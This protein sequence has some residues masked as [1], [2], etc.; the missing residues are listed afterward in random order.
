MTIQYKTI[1]SKNIFVIKQYVLILEG[2]PFL[3]FVVSILWDQAFEFSLHVRSVYV[4]SLMVEM[5]TFGEE[6]MVESLLSRSL[7]FFATNFLK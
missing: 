1:T 5:F 7:C 4:K 2:F 3:V 6:T